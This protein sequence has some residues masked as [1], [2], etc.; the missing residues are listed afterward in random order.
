MSTAPRPPVTID[1]E[2]YQGLKDVMTQFNS[3][4]GILCDQECRNNQNVQKLYQNYQNWKYLVEEGPDQLRDAEGEY[5]IAD[6][7]TQWYDNYR[8]SRAKKEAKR[9]IPVLSNNVEEKKEEVQRNISYYESQ[10][11]YVKRMNDLLKT[12]GDKL[13]E[14]AREIASLD[15]QKNIAHRL[16]TYY[17]TQKMDVDWYLHYVKILYWIVGIVF[18]IMVARIVYKNRKQ[19]KTAL[20]TT[21]GGLVV[22]L[23][24]PF[25]LRKVIKTISPTKC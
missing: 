1:A 15:A 2:L 18:A 7:G 25:I 11:L 21:V 12:Y 13:D 24:G 22:Y 19:P 6:K 23:S 3:E 20:A 5:Y 8:E 16:T 9:I 4:E 10:L 17:N 14:D